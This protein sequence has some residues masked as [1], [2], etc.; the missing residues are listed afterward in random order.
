MIDTPAKDQDKFV[1]RL[2]DGMRDQIKFFADASNRSMNAE[3]VARLAQ[4][5]TN[6]FEEERVEWIKKLAV[7]DAKAQAFLDV[8]KLLTSVIGNITGNDPETM[9]LLANT[10]RN[11]DADPT[12][13][14]KF[15]SVHKGDKYPQRALQL[16]DGPK[17]E[18]EES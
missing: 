5:F 10:I 17:E 7:A 3:I 11:I 13:S 2:P 8:I 9:K 16:D 15:S 1:L 18:D 4:S 14:E 6:D 12:L